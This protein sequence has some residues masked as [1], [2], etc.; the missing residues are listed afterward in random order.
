MK[1]AAVPK[2]PLRLVCICD[3]HGFHRKLTLPPGDKL[4]HSGDFM[5]KGSSTEEIDD[6]NAWLGTLPFRIN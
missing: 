4:I 5:V 3:T 2:S 6:F 1:P